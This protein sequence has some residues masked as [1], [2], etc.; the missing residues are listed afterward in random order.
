MLV[1]RRMVVGLI[2]R[3]VEILQRDWFVGVSSAVVGIWVGHWS[4]LADLRPSPQHQPRLAQCVAA[5]VCEGAMAQSCR[6]Q[7]AAR[8]MQGGE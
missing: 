4:V 7:A 6:V 2:W 3:A 8:R 1:V 5:C